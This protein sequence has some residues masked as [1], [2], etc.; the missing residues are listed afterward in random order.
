LRTPGCS[1]NAASATPVSCAAGNPDSPLLAPVRQILL[2]VTGPVV[3]IRQALA[4]LPGITCAFLFGSF[5]ARATG[6]EGPAPN[7][8]DVMVIGEPDAAAVYRACRQV[9]DQV[10][11]VVNP[12]IM[13]PAEWAKETGFTEQVR[14]TP[15]VEIMGDLP[16]RLSSH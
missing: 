11:R 6:V 12:T 2:T 5:A 14:S 9:G 7:D 3:L 13:T 15:T 4:D 8:I 16:A 1:S 10:G